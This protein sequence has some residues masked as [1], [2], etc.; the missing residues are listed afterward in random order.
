MIVPYPFTEKQTEHQ[1]GYSKSEEK[2][3]RLA[4][5]RVSIIIPSKKELAVGLCQCE[6]PF[7]F[8]AQR[9]E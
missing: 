3:K 4:M 7:D 2:G 9:L 1:G 8:A 6:E 5:A